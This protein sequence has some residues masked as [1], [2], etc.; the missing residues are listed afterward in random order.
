MK[1]ATYNLLKGGS[2]LTHWQ[3][4]IE[5]HKVDLLLLQESHRPERHLPPYLIQVPPERIVWSC[6]TPNQW[7]SGIYTSSGTLKHIPVPDFNGWVV[8]AELSGADWQ[9]KDERI[10]IFSIHAPGGSGS[11]AGRVSAILDVILTLAD[12]C[13]LIIGGDFNL[14]VSRSLSPDRPT[15]KKD[16]AIQDRL[17]NEFG[18]MNCWQ[19]VHPGTEPVQTLR[20]LREPTT[21]YHCDGIFVPRAWKVRLRDCTVLAGDEWNELSDHNPVIADLS[22]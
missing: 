21:V 9:A 12:G 13:Y 4:M 1:I 18:L 22:N 2:K 20:W 16:L 7:G 19:E 17:E 6:A 3:K 14:S 11:Y 10:R 8:G 5:D 15:T